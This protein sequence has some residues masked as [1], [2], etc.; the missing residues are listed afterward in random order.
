MCRGF[1]VPNIGLAPQVRT[2]MIKHTLLSCLSVVMMSITNPLAAQVTYS[3]VK[4]DLPPS[5]MQRL[6]QLDLDLDHGDYNQSD[7]TFTTT[8]PQEDLLKLNQAG[9]RYVIIVEDEVAHFQQTNDGS[10]DPAMLSQTQKFH[11]ESSCSSHL[12]GIATPAGF[13][14]G[15]YAGYYTF[16]EMEARIDSLVNHFPDIASKIILPQTTAGGRRLIVLKISDNVSVT[17]PEPKAMYTGLH[18]AREGM[19]M[20]NLFFFMQYLAEN[21]SSD[22]R[23]KALIDN[24]E[25]YFIPCVNPDGYVY[26][27]INTPGGGGMWRKN[28]RNNG[29]GR[30]GV[31]LN[32]NYG[33][34]WGVSGPN[35]NISTNPSSDSYIGPSAFSEPETQ[36]IR[37]FAQSRHFSIVID[38][39]AYGNYY[40]TPYGVPAN[41]PF[42][43]ADNRFYTYASALMSRYN[44]YFAGDGLQTV[45]YY[46]VG[47]S[48]DYHMA[49]DI[50]VGSKSKTYGYTVEVGPSAMGF[51]PTQS[52]ILPL[53]KSMFFANM[54]M[55]Y[56]AGSYYELQDRDRISLGNVSGHFNFSLLRTGIANDPVTVSVLPLQNIQTVGGSFSVSGLPAYG[57]SVQGAIS[58]ALTPGI[59][60]G[61]KIRFVYVI[62]SGGIVLQDTIEKIFQPS[63]LLYD[64]LENGITNWNLTGTWGTTTSAAYAGS[65]SL[66]ESPAGNYTGSSNTTATYSQ[67]FDLSNATSAYLSF[68][69][70][71]RAENGIDKLQVQGSPSG[72]GTGSSF[73]SLC[74][75]HTVAE[76]NTAP[77]L[78]GMRDN[79]TRE[80]IDLSDYLG[81]T[82]FGLRF[83]FTSN[84][85]GHNDGFYIDDIE[86]VKAPAI[87]LRHE[88]A[89]GGKLPGYI[90]TGNSLGV[91]PNPAS[92]RL[93]MLFQVDSKTKLNVTIST[94]SGIVVKHMSVD[95]QK[96]EIH[97]LD[98]SGLKPQ[99]YILTITNLSTGKKTVY[100]VMKI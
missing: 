62:S 11:F 82:Q 63:V 51:W 75:Q 20:M 67:T 13:I 50:G 39:H 87:V 52:N 8:V 44:S 34:D 97:S 85:S 24:R 47:N 77:S 80:T 15:S 70:K 25:L 60:T 66:S 43:I 54:Q 91:Y 9:I 31:D 68:W 27:E 89:P 35:I 59:T 76:N 41:H 16:A 3:R 74:G 23:I 57:D 64:N 100:K 90:S 95:A 56:M 5:G 2:P 73:V 69:V 6:L 98:L 45:N 4:I 48:R 21:Y 17:E 38:H 58:F 55:A 92:D 22:D 40:V 30:Y 46:A 83:L 18:H 61:E 32:R 71:H 94:T 1:G 36:A 26:N 99:L 86:L 79:W 42:T 12:T 19:S 72:N 78:T 7:S 29:S 10:G 37:E 93:N 96:D 33:V 49:G 28:R 88:D 53:A 81:A 65:R 14:A 84:S